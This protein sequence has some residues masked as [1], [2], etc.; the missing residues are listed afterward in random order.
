MNRHFI[1]GRNSAIS[2]AND[3]PF[4][5]GITRSV[6]RRS[7]LV[8]FVLMRF[9]ASEGLSTENTSKPIFCSMRR[10]MP[11]MATSSSTSRTAGLL[12]ASRVITFSDCLPS[13]T[14]E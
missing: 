7:N 10:T 2:L 13:L 9:N 4:I 5:S 11:S 3:L 12:R 14:S 1:S 6:S 8:G